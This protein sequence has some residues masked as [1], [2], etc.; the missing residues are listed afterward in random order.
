M[1]LAAVY[2]HYKQSWPLKASSW[3]Q[4]NIGSMAGGRS[5]MCDWALPVP[6]FSDAHAGY[7]AIAATNFT[8]KWA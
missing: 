5:A 3:Y 2:Q 8:G 1:I 4:C 7:R 6:F